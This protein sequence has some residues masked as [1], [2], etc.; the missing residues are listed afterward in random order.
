MR[1]KISEKKLL[2]PNRNFDLD[3]TIFFLVST[4][5]L[6]NLTCNPV[7]QEVQNDFSTILARVLAFIGKMAFSGGFNL[8]FTYTAEI[9]PADLRSIGFAI[10]CFAARISAFLAPF[11]LGLATVK[12]WLPGV[13]FSLMELSCGIITLKLPETRGKSLLSDIKE[14]E[15]VYFSG[16]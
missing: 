10:V 13:V 6:E 15:R 7:T 1:V 2:Q 3:L 9:Y 4:I 14:T 12:S 5:L 16:E 8:I 11:I